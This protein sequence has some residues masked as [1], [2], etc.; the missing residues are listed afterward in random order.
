MRGVQNLKA[1]VVDRKCWLMLDMAAIPAMQNVRIKTVQRK[2]T[3]EVPV[4]RSPIQT[5]Q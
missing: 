4:V 1:S 2:G 3:R 5:P